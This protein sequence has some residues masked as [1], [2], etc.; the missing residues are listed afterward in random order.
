MAE[1]LRGDCDYGWRWKEDV[2]AEFQVMV[3]G[4]AKGEYQ[5]SPG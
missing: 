3:I 2:R 5:K 4:V 1:D